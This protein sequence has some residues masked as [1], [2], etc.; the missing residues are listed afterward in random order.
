MD[1]ELKKTVTALRQRKG[2]APASSTGYAKL[3][4]LEEKR[5]DR[6]EQALVAFHSAIVEFSDAAEDR[7]LR[8][9]R[10]IK[11]DVADVDG[12]LSS[13]KQHL[14][15]P[16]TLL[17]LNYD[18]LCSAWEDLKAL[19][20]RWREVVA[21]FA[22]E[23]DTVERERSA[24]IRQALQRLVSTLNDI[25]FALP[26]EVERLAEKEALELNRVMLANRESVPR[27]RAAKPP[28]ACIFQPLTRVA[29][30]QSARVGASHAAARASPRPRRRPQA[31]ACPAGA[32]AA[33]VARP[34][35]HP[36]LRRAQ[37]DHVHR[38]ARARAGACRPAQR[39]AALASG[40]SRAAAAATGGVTATRRP[41]YSCCGR[42]AA[43]VGGGGGGGGG[44]CQ[45]G[46]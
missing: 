39:A 34:R 7:V 1:T 36:V 25:A 27:F 46:F 2:E 11:D 33:T 44:H 17:A 38:P 13:A 12:K 20:E 45:Q 8:A 40:P 6:H 10:Q 4:S 41:H 32:V 22:F 31:L 37:F 35:P 19:C 5:K 28:R 14:A 42:G 26:G 30:A 21:G 23:L 43:R 24:H 16:D 9:S 15:L 18:Q 29:A 3:R